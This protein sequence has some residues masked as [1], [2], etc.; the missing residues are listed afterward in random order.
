M[1]PLL[2]EAKQGKV[3]VYFVDA[4]HFLYGGYT[5]R[6]W[7]MDRVFVR[8]PPGRQRFNVLG[9]LNAVTHQVVS[10]VTEGVVNSWSM[11]DLFTKLREKHGRERVAVILDNAGYHRGYVTRYAANFKNIEL[12]F[13]PPYSPQL[14]LIERLW[15]FVKGK[16]V[17][18]MYHETFRRFCDQIEKC[19]KECHTRW[20]CE[21]Q[22]L[23]TWNFQEFFKIK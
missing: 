16:C 22:S 7:S 4:S 13:L 9:A 14:N 12:L 18:G 15:K 21:L 19:I 10:I 3:H 11:N 23:L 8:T 5:G 1:D 20:K 6:F 2:E 17:N